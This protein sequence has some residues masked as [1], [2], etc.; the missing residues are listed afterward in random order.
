MLGLFDGVLR[1]VQWL[2][3]ATLDFSFSFSFFFDDDASPYFINKNKTTD[4]IS[5]LF[6]AA[7]SSSS[8]LAAVALVG[9]IATNWSIGFLIFC[10]KRKFIFDFFVSISFPKG[11]LPIN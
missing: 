2:V 5:D 3:D 10:Q 8:K 11:F 4:P 9:L 7:T 6:V 1:L